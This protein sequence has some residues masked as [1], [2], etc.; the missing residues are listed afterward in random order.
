MPS[1]RAPWR[2]ST[3]ILLFLGACND[4]AGIE[5]GNP[6]D[7]EEKPCTTDADCIASEPECRKGKCQ[8]EHCSFTNNP[9]DTKL[10]DKRQI[11]GDCQELFCDGMG[12]VRIVSD[13]Q[14][15]EDDRDP[16]TLDEC[17]GMIPRHTLKTQLP[18]YTGPKGTQDIG[19][20][21]AGVQLCDGAGIPISECMDEVTPS[22]EN[23]YSP[24]DEDC[25]GKINEG[26]EGCV[27]TPSDTIE[28]YTGLPDTKGK[29]T[30]KSGTQTCNEYGY[31]YGS[32]QGE[33]TPRREIC[34][35]LSPDDEDCDGN[36]N[37]TSDCCGDMFLDPGEECD[38]GNLDSSDGCTI[39]CKF[40]TCGDGFAQQGEQCDDGNQDN[41]DACS[42]ICRVNVNEVV[43]GGNHTCARLNAVKVKCWG[44]N[45]YGQL[46]LGDT[47]NRGDEPDE[48]RSHLPTIDVGNDVRTIA[49]GSDHSCVLL[50]VGVVKCWGR[51]NYGQLGLGSTTNQTSAKLSKSVNLGLGKTATA[52]S[53]GGEHTCVILDDGTVKCWGRNNY[54]QLGLGDKMN[55]GSVTG[56]TV[57]S[58]PTVNLGPSRTAKAIAA[59]THHTCALLDNDTLKCWGYNAFGQLGLGNTQS[60]GDEVYEMGASL[61]SVS[62]GTG[63][64]AKSIAAGGYHTCAILDDNTLKCWGNNAFGQLGLGNTQNYGDKMSPALPSVS[65]GMGRSAKAI[66]AGGYHTCSILDNWTLKCWGENDK[67]QLGLGSTASQGDNPNEMGDALP[68]IELW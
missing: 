44:D 62:L 65:L 4:L 7:Y 32:C 1:P 26:G 8:N 56:Q 3:A 46:G 18:C 35:N 38:D 53:A 42:S 54:G 50:K 43:A 41:D 67:G 15:V 29:G 30:C 28:C 2:T 24:L 59:G 47:Q 57:A 60:R 22:K 51:N 27:C 64:K 25:N 6:F 34:D 63:R 33:I 48:M 10:S 39:R 55:R 45:Q 40:A 20:C 31:G 12:S 14:D 49:V 58:L 37:E 61:P 66:A 21:R 13:I 5:E 11:P 17:I 16:C 9:T 52:I 68:I 19:I 23:C 36:T